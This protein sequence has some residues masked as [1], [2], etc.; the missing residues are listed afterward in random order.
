MSTK[1][2]RAFGL[3]LALSTLTAAAAMADVTQ[4][5]VGI[6]EGAQS[7]YLQGR[8]YQSGISVQNMG[9]FQRARPSFYGENIQ[10]TAAGVQSVQQAQEG[11]GRVNQSLVDLR[12]LRQRQFSGGF[13]Y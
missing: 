1:V 10:Q 7:Q 6:Q 12:N 3:A 13:R 4:T 2:Y 8:G 5:A 9:Q 11:Y